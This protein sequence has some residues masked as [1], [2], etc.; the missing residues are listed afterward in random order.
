PSTRIRPPRASFPLSGPLS[1]AASAQS[2]RIG[3]I[4][5][6]SSLVSTHSSL[7][8]MLATPTESRASSGSDHGAM[9][10]PVMSRIPSPT[11]GLR[12]PTSLV[13]ALNRHQHRLESVRQEVSSSESPAAMTPARNSSIESFVAG[14]GSGSGSGSGIKT[15]T[16]LS[17]IRPP[18]S[19]GSLVRTLGVS[20]KPPH[21]AS[22][23]GTGG[24]SSNS[25]SGT[26]T[27]A[28]R[29]APGGHSLAAAAAATASTV[30]RRQGE[31]VAA[32]VKTPHTISAASSF[33][34]TQQASS[35]GRLRSVRSSTTSL[36]SA[37]TS[38][39]ST[40]GV[41]GGSVDAVTAQ[42]EAGGRRTPTAPHR[43]P[44]VRGVFNQQNE[45][46]T[47]RPVHTPDLIPRRFDPRL[48]ERAMTPMLKS[49]VGRSYS[50]RAAA[51][52]FSNGGDDESSYEYQEPHSAI[53][54]L[55]TL[56]EDP[57]SA[58]TPVSEETPL[59]AGLPPSHISPL[60]SPEIPSGAGFLAGT[61]SKPSFLSWGR[62]KSA[63][64]APVSAIPQPSPSRVSGSAASARPPSLI[65]SLRKSKSLWSLKS[66]WSK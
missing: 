65:P 11:S 25:S 21:S 50:S 62:G 46:L 27:P 37:Y 35:I 43:R 59:S 29:R 42:W 6:R 17:G 12:A 23:G 53:Q 7:T 52:N 1:A 28:Y 41:R 48:V 40:G 19:T 64:S 26:L 34:G 18:A 5:P 15:P 16:P 38:G 4:S 44:D 61:F 54:V 13:A 63:S 10:S 14:G 49:N 47:L 31:R 8:D 60:N 45:F 30:G 22:G 32:A 39:V 51:Q 2:L 66:A 55:P 58:E 33:S 24:N 56:P 9:D 3:S 20:I 57:S 36:R